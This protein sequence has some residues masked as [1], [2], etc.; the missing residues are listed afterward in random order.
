MDATQLK[1][2]IAFCGLVCGL[3][4]HIIDCSCK[5]P[6]KKGDK[7]DKE[8][9][10]HRACCLKNGYDGC[11]ECALFPCD[12]GRFIDENKGQMLAFL[13][14]IKDFDKGKFINRLL[15]NQRKGIKYGMGGAYRLKPYEEVNRLLRHGE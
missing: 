8:F 10:C 6:I 11:W 4:D 9:C 1:N 15:L 14:Y 7:C 12:Q 2:S 5:A 3:C 13:Q